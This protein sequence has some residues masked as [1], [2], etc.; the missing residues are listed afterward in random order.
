M[1][2]KMAEDESRGKRA[3]QMFSPQGQSTSDSS[4]Q[5]A[6]E[7]HILELISLGAA[8]P[9]I[10][11]KLCTS[12]DVQIGDVVSLFSLPE[13]EIGHLCAEAQSAMQMGLNIFSSKD[14]LAPD[15]TLLAT[16]E[17]YGCGSR[18]P[19]AQE[20]QLIER[21]VSLAAVA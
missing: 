7:G 3:P 8:L 4:C 5:L 20:Y 16:L 15:G 19:V 18:R 14:I 12:L 6:D 13:E 9:W 2:A 17:I 1:E 21:V 10:L 11:N